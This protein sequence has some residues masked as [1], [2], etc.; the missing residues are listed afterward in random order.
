MGHQSAPIIM[1]L[2]TRTLASNFIFLFD[3]IFFELVAVAVVVCCLFFIPFFLRYMRR[4]EFFFFFSCIMFGWKESCHSVSSTILTHCV[5][6]FLS[7]SFFSS[8]C[9]FFQLIRPTACGQN[10]RNKFVLVG[11]SVHKINTRQRNQP[12]GAVVVCT[13]KVC[14]K[15]RKRESID[16]CI[17]NQRNWITAA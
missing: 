3:L 8:F 4:V 12:T 13:Q 1:T 2:T 15:E 11:H 5:R 17:V 14:K 7:W 6:F 10:T 16:R 9:W